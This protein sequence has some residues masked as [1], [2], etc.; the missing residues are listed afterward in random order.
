MFATEGD[1]QKRPGLFSLGRF[2]VAGAGFE[3]AT[4]GL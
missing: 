2:F 3:P 4:F 1:K